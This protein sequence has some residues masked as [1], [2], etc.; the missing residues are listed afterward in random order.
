M[1]SVPLAAEGG[2]DHVPSSLRNRPLAAVGLGTAPRL[3][4]VKSVIPMAVGVPNVPPPVIG[5]VTGIVVVLSALSASA[6]AC[7]VD[8]GLLASDVLST[9]P[10]PTKA[11][12]IVDQ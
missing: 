4:V 3:V 10:R 11:L 6:A 1:L 2:N 12:S 8:T 7:A 9:L 5:A